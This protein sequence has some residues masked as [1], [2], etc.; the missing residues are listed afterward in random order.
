MAWGGHGGQEGGVWWRVVCV[1]GGM[2]GRGH[3]WQ[4]GV[5]GRGCVWQEV[6]V[7]GG[8]ECIAGET[9]NAAD[10]T[11]PTGMDSC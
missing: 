4:W 8:C 11:H 1:T 9:A 5:H 2:H 7:A 10:G 6:C 3:A